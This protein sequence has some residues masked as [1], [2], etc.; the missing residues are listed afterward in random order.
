V[1]PSEAGATV[2]DAKTAQPFPEL[3]RLA[4]I[5]EAR[6]EAH[7]GGLWGSSQ[8][9]A[10]ASLAS[11]IAGPWLVAA[12]T[13][14]EAQVFAEDLAA[15]GAEATWLPA[16]EEGSGLHETPDAETLRQRLSVAQRL[17]G[18][19]EHR[20]RIV[21]A[22]VLSLIQPVPSPTDIERDYLHLQVH[23]KLDPESLLERLVT[24][25]YTRTPL[26]EKPG[27]ISLRG[28]IL[29]VFPFASQL[30]LRIEMFGEEIESLRTFDPVDQRSVQ[31]LPRVEVC[32]AADAGSVEDGHGVLPIA[33]FPKPTVVAEIEPLRIQDRA[34]GFRIR[35]PAHARALARHVEAAG[36]HRRI[37]LQSLP[38]EIDFGTRSVQ[39]L[40]VGI[41]EAP[42]A[43]REATPAGSRTIVACR[44]PA[45]EHRF[46]ELLEEAG[47]ASGVETRVGS[48]AKG[49]RIPS[50]RL[51]VANH[52]EL[53]GVLGRRTAARPPPAHRVRA[54]Q[55]FF[56]LKPGDLVVHAVHGLARFA[57][58]KRI[59]RNGGEEEHLYL[60]FEDDV[61]LYVPSSRIDLVQ[62]YVGAGGAGAVGLDRIGG[63][64]FR[65]RREKVERALFDLAADL[66]EVQA[67]R[68]L[69]KRNPWASDPGLVRD[70]IGSF[71]FA[72]TKDQADVDREIAGDLASERP[73]DRLLCG[74][75]G[76][77]KTE[78]AV[79]AAFRVVSGGG[80]VAV[81]VPTTV[82][83]EQH[84]ETFRERLADFPVEVAELSRYVEGKR[85]KEVVEGLE[86]GTVDVVVGTHRILS[87]DVRFKNLGLVVV[88]EEQ[89]FGVAHKEHFKRLR[90][91][92]D[93][94]TLSATPIPRTLHMS[95][96]GVR[97][98]SALTMPPEG[99]QEI[100]TRLG[101]TDDDEVLREILLREKNRGGQ[102]FFLYNRVASIAGVAARLARL[103]PECSFAIGHGQMGARE[104][105]RVMDAFTRGEVDVLV[106]TTI[107]ES[108]IDI[109]AAGTI[110]IHD[111]DQFG[112]AELHQLRGR[113]GRGAHKAYCC[114]LV[115]RGK[116]LREEARTRLKAL[117]EMNQLGAGFAI[118]MK[119]L[120]IRGAGN[121]LGPQQSGHIAAVGYDMYC[122]LL[123]RAV[124]SLQAGADVETALANPPE[125]EAAELELGIRAFLPE[126]WIPDARTRL[127]VHRTLSEIR[128]AAD[129]GRVTEML[130]DR[131]GRVPAEAENLI[132]SLLLKSRLERLSIRRLS[133]REGFYLVEYADRVELEHGLELEG[134]ELRPVKTGLAHLQIPARHRSPEAALG[135]FEGLL[136]APDEAPRMAESGA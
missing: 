10:L 71:P 42:R 67:R 6:R 74:D 14:A 56:E 97:D 112:L 134:V 86:R 65:R 4:E 89:R 28:E 83:A 108:G 21:V 2:F 116:P 94:L 106:A 136:K 58:L 53:A 61:A 127:E 23:S 113:V 66:I 69:K 132:R 3:D 119:D 9:L 43:L 33:L 111:A 118:S 85:E 102:V 87:S 40:S 19:P 38:A 13:D 29:D 11:R 68:A 35:S 52:R 84:L 34:E 110:V 121:I 32:V 88:D 100:E 18:A 5:L 114:L 129:A 124:E 104:L 128:V 62:R 7:G 90:A 91:E 105:Q 109:P 8:A 54:I 55:S 131:F 98:I 60:L 64:S 81:L 75:V 12:S 36:L 45:E 126:D 72:D 31:S 78:L 92:V 46:R 24:A 48:V 15:F 96:S 37:S 135:W 107:I 41:R 26:S 76:F 63:A 120:E 123:K 47:G 93:L 82:L 39:A 103:A 25:G 122:R 51:V 79:R 73:M 59:E 20:P 50:L 44:T 1:T 130:R 95:L 57:G 30:P 133:W 115:E 22:S 16:R 80:Q 77:G 27:E 17:A 70:L 101:Y 99:R 117:E 125:E 49:F